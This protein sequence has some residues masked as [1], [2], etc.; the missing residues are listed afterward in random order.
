MKVY[1]E[2]GQERKMQKLRNSNGRLPTAL[3]GIRR[4]RNNA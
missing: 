2:R 3:T 1:N 4:E